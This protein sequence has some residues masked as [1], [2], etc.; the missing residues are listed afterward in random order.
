MRATRRVVLM[1]AAATTA[2]SA[3]EVPARAHAPAVPVPRVP[4]SSFEG[5]TDDDRLSAFMSWAAAQTHRGITVELDEARS[6]LFTRSHTL[7]D[8]FSILGSP[9]PQDQARSSMPVGQQVVLRTAGGWF[10]LGG[11]QTFGCSFQ[12][13]SIDGAADSRLVEGHPSYVLWTSVFRD[14]SAQNCGGVL[15]SSS[16]PLLNTACTVDGWWN[17]NNVR[18]RAFSLGGS[19]TFFKPSQMLLDSP[20]DLLPVSGFLLSYDHQSKGELS[21]LYCTAEGHSGILL[22]GGSG[23]TVRG[24]VVEGRNADAPCH[25]ALLRVEGGTWLIRDNVL[26][27]AMADPA[28]TGRD[29]GGVVHVAS[30]TV[31]IDGVVHDRA[32]AVSEETPLVHVAAGRVRVRNVMASFRP[33]VRQAVP[34][35]VDA[36]DTVRVVTG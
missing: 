5:F 2:A 11:P 4:L 27:Y 33:V 31:L 20:A 25:G 3:A 14:L 30:G 26:N 22:R 19:D 21:G 36:D 16:Q 7:Y 29:D 10:G 18:D 6:Y 24:N 9:R 28:A 17:V 12:G 23:V 8:G 1:G 35:L 32:S 13:L 34:G 15:G